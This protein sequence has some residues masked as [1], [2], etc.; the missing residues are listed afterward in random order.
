MITLAFLQNPWF[1]PGTQPRLIELYARDQTFHRRVLALSATGRALR[2]MFGPLYEEIVWDNANTRHGD[3]RDAMLPPD[4]HHIARRL[5][6]VK[7]DVV[8]L[9][10]RQAQIGWD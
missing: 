6:E 1:K 3:V 7:P 9:L 4:P 8:L 2:K 5:A 10:G